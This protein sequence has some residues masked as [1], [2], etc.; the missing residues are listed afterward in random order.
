MKKKQDIDQ[1][2]TICNG[3]ATKWVTRQEAENFYLKLLPM[4][5]GSEH[6]RYFK[7]YTQLKMGLAICRDEEEYQVMTIC[8]DKV[9]KWKTRQEAEDFYLKAMSMS[10]G[11]E[12]QR[13]CEIY[14]QLKMG[15]AVC[16]DDDD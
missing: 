6:N 12:R 4:C 13:Y 15:F 5:D 1:V 8:Y 2:V 11:S 16:R 14:S 7:I 9:E 3:K 10:D